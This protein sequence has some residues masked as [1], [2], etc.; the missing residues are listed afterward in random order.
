MQRLTRYSLLLRQILQNTKDHEDFKDCT[1]ALERI[2][3][4]LHVANEAAREQA[5]TLKLRRLISHIKIDEDRIEVSFF[6]NSR[7][8]I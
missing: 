1:K 5:E 3:A 4:L 2:E 7:K 8:L 6:T